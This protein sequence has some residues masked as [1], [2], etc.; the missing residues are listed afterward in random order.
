MYFTL[1]PEGEINRIT[2]E[3]LAEKVV[4]IKRRIVIR[5]AA[6]KKMTSRNSRFGF[7]FAGSA[8]VIASSVPEV[9]AEES[10]AGVALLFSDSVI[11]PPQ[12]SVASREFTASA[13][14]KIKRLSCS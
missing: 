1:D 4:A 14:P 13:L 11:A 5:N 9:S 12:T 6:L 7:T 3:R 2:G 8:S 10:S